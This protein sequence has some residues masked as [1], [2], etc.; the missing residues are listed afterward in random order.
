MNSDQ[1]EKLMKEIK[2]CKRELKNTIEASE[3][4]LRLDIEG[5]K[6]LIQ[7]LKNENE[8]IKL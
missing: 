8:V 3:A 4:R 7:E 6:R 2:S 5:Q 1:F